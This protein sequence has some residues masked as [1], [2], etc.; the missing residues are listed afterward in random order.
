M[1]SSRD[2]FN[3]TSTFNKMWLPKPS[4]YFWKAN[5]LLKA[6]WGSTGREIQKEIL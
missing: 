5:E 4:C 6:Q 1:K 2:S 3:G